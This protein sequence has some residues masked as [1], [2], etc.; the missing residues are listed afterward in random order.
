M[1]FLQYVRNECKKNVSRQVMKDSTIQFGV[2][3]ISLTSVLVWWFP[4]K[5]AI[6]PKYDPA[7]RIINIW[8]C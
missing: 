2:G 6:D 4:A 7:S 3:S 5:P 8:L 1:G